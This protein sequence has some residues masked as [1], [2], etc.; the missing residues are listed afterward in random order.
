MAE[1]MLGCQ[2]DCYTKVMLSESSFFNHPLHS[3][4]KI[5]SMSEGK[6]VWHYL[7]LLKNSHI[8]RSAIFSHE[9][10]YS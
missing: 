9:T 7:W 1:A 2:C 6:E 5:A 10:H 3:D 4:V 8:P